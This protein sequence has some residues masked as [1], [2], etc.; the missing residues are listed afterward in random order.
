MKKKFYNFPNVQVVKI[1][2]RTMTMSDG[3]LLGGGDSGEN[4]YDGD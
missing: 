2:P 3:S 4:M 1:E